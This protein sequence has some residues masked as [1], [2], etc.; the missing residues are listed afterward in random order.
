MV[1]RRWGGNCR[2]AL[3]T[4]Y[5]QRPIRPALLGQ[6]C[7]YSTLGPLVQPLS[8]S[9]TF[10]A[11]PTTYN[12]DLCWSANLNSALWPWSP[13]FWQILVRWFSTVR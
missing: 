9:L 13:N 1:G 11:L 5:D 12:S 4:T 10:L 7:E 6:R 3:S 8:Y 2:A